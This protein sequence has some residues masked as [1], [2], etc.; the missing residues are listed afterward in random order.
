MP[1]ESGCSIETR[2]YG[3]LLDPWDILA[4]RFERVV[5]ENIF[6][7]IFVNIGA[8]LPRKNI[9]VAIWLSIIFFISFQKFFIFVV[10]R[11][12]VGR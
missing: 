5:A 12:Q 4:F 7:G 8:V 2:S 3:F 11:M 1:A 10:S 6:S 9:F